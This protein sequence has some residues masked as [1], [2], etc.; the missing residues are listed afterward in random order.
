MSHAY[1]ISGIEMHIWGSGYGIPHP[2]AAPFIFLRTCS[3]S[4]VCWS[5]LCL[6]TGVIEVGM[7]QI[8]ECK[9]WNLIHLWNIE[10]VHICRSSARSRFLAVTPP[11]CLKRVL[12]FLHQCCLFSQSKQA[13]REAK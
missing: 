11:V 3:V 5:A 4:S 6:K 8:S 7:E 1:E 2:G 13:N 10:H 12:P 9:A